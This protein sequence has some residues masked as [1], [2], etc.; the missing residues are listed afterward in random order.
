M[1]TDASST[2]SD[3]ENSSDADSENL[4]SGDINTETDADIAELNYPQFPNADREEEAIACVLDNQQCA[5]HEE[6]AASVDTVMSL[7]RQ[8]G[9]WEEVVRSTENCVWNGFHRFMDKV[10]ESIVWK[11]FQGFLCLFPNNSIV[12][13]SPRTITE[14]GLSSTKRSNT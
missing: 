13:R 9:S 4:D 3:S 1:V 11:K 5:I 2:Q 7:L 6:E 12:S 14:T 8:A 10:A